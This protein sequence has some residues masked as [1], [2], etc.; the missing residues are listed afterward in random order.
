MR[1]CGALLAFGV[2]CGWC[3]GADAQR[4][5]GGVR[6]EHYSLMITPDLAAAKFSGVESIDVV[7]DK[8]TSAITLNAAEIEFGAVKAWVGSGLAHGV[9]AEQQKERHKAKANTEILTSGQND[10]SI[11][12]GGGALTATV[13]LDAAKEQATFTFAQPLPAG[14]LTL[15]IAFKGTL[16][17]KLRGFYLSKSKTRNYAVTQFEATDARR[18]FP[19]FDEPALKATFD[20]ALV[21]DSGDTAISNTKIVSDKPGPVAG[22]HTLLFATTP[23]M[24]TYLVAFLV[25]DFVC[26]HGKSDGVPIRACATA[27]PADPEKVKLT[28]FALQAAKWN[29]KY[30][31]K[32]FG[33]KYPMSKLDM[34]AIP[35][36]EAGAMENFGCITYRETEML[37][38]EKNGTLPAKKDVATT[39]AHE[40]AHQWF[41]DL[42]TPV[43]WDNLWLNEGFATWMETKAA[44]QWQPKWHY[45]EDLAVDLNGTLD[46]DSVRTTRAI[47]SQAETPA[48]INEM[49]DD[50]AYGKAGAVIDMVEN[51]VGDETFRRGVHEYLAAHLYG[52]ATAEDFWD[53][54]ARVSGQPVDKIMRSFVEQPGVPLVT[55]SEHGEVSQSRFSVSAS[56]EE[57]ATRE[58]WTVPVCFK[59]TSCTLLRPD[60]PQMDAPAASHAAPFLYANAGDQGYYRTLYPAKMQAAIVTNAETG[61]TPPE[62]IGL[63]G[64][65]WALLRAGQGTVGDF[66]DLVMA[67][68]RDPNATVMENALGRVETIRT[69]IATDQDRERLDAIVRRELGSVYT[70]L[71]GASKH[72]SYDHAELRETL[73]EALGNAKDPIVISEANRVATALFLGQKPDDPMIGDAAVALVTRTGDTAIYD[74][75]QRVAQNATDPDLKE[76]ALHVLTRF[77]N[78]LLV[79]RT[80][81]YAISDNVRN[82]DSWTLIALLLERRETQDL[83]WEF[84]K[85]HWAEIQKKSTINSGT[86][87]V[88]ATGTFCTVQ[89]RHEVAEFFGAHSVE[90]SGR[91]L[92]KSLDSID[93]CVHLREAQ[94]PELRRWL[95]AHSG[96]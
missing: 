29:L 89:K 10:A 42:V 13:A 85:Q 51:Y 70:A 93:D 52:N 36:F 14:H 67:V 62:R 63:L 2:V 18:A 35:D 80:L 96:S 30:Y 27:D 34:V 4:L 90:G 69:L 5:P 82:Q 91:A 21:V 86:R 9:P 16:N 15:A 76:A 43:W 73:F 68:K 17:T 44:E 77:E 23:K 75:L 66:L 1:W 38:D 79:M 19:C 8:P 64:D 46:R 54:Q 31:D 39:V 37:V 6:P 7:L 48:E 60:Q 53:T 59:G 71:G 49:F 88:E 24:S 95:D 72:E 20:V 22:K 87:I 94:E 83:A 57:H 25:G 41:G 40:M 50:I 92:A 47:R 61:L 32:Y 28:K 33:I 81:L 45:D 84:V 56:P 78:P 58:V 11:V 65:R 55:V 3:G 26:S 74:K 12:G